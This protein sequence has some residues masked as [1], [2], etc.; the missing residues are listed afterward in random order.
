MAQKRPIRFRLLPESEAQGRVREIYAELKQALGVPFVS[1]LIRAYGAYPQ[2]LEMFWDVV[3]PVLASRQFFTLA[4]R[5]RA[6]AYTRA[7]NYFEIADLGAPLVAMKFSEGA[8]A[9]LT[10]AVDLFHYE[11]PVMLLLATAQ[12][13][14]FE[15]RLGQDRN[16]EP[17]PAPVPLDTPPLV[18]PEETAPAPIRKI[19]DD[20]KRTLGLP[21]INLPYLAFARW[22]DFL[23]AYWQVLRPVVESP[24]YHETQYGIRDTAWAF[25]R[26]FPRTIDLTQERL[27]ESG[28]P[29]T[30]V[31]ALARTTEVFAKMLSGLVLNLA[32]AKI[33][34][35]GG[36]RPAAA[37]PKAPH[38]AA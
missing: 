11:A 20:M 14:A 13:Q 10:S 31:T 7:H 21:F 5:L 4:D 26:E 24:V 8:R 38:R 22:P 18:I 27:E 9:E 1:G 33:A 2:F 17:A 37:V 16:I 28:I 25:A 19:Y 23:A 3:Q 35:E 36:N 29:E 15:G 32:V 12:L 30:A 6:D 34:V